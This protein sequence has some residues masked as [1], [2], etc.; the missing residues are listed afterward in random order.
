[1]PNSCGISS[2]FNTLEASDPVP[3]Q[4]PVIIYDGDCGFCERWAKLWQ[5]RGEGRLDVIPY[6]ELNGR[7]PQVDPDQ[8]A[9][10]VHLAEPTP[11]GIRMS[12]ASRA[13]I[14]SHL[15]A[16]DTD[17]DR[18][19]YAIAVPCLSILLYLP[20]RLV[21]RYRGFFN[22]ILFGQQPDTEQGVSESN[23]PKENRP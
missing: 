1:M 10:A 17:P 3:N 6:Q 8:C 11:S 12:T 14:R 7:L 13:A 16:G 4:S 9:R 2:R 19:I 21:A 5:K 18:G 15:I 23:S 22:R 20:Y